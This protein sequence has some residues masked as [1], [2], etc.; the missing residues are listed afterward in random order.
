[1]VAASAI[2]VSV[3]CDRIPEMLLAQENEP[4]Q[5]LLLDGTYEAL[6][7]GTQ[8]PETASAMERLCRTYWYP[9]WSNQLN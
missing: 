9:V 5:T 8:S 7:I 3:D 1:M 6:G 2:I 4:T